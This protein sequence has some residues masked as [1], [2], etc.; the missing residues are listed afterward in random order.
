MANFTVPTE[1]DANASTA[2]AVSIDDVLVFY[3]NV[4]GLRTKTTD[5]CNAVQ[6]SNY[7]IFVLTETGLNDSINNNEIFDDSFI[8]YRCDRSSSDKTRKGGVLLSSCLHSSGHSIGL[9]QL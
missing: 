1:L 3:H 7:K 6:M 2:D 5:F 9:E 8:V 4:N